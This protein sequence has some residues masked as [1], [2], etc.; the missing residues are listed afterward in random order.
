MPVHR[1]DAASTQSSHPSE[2]EEE[3]RPFV[4]VPDK[5]IA[6]AFD[7]DGIIGKLYEEYEP[8]EPQKLMAL[9]IQQA[10]RKGENAAIEA[11]TGV[12]KSMAYLLPL[13]LLAKANNV[14]TGVATKTNTLLDQLVNKEL[15]LA[16]RTRRSKD[17][18]I[19]PVC[20]RSSALMPKGHSN[21]W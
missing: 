4:L 5:E 15:P 11:G 2:N 21:T 16:Y 8:R 10:L 3:P 1:G 7:P 13:A 6:Q 14:P 18:R 19:T 9:S 12:G 17:S 20:V